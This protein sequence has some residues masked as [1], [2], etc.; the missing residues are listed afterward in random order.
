MK[1]HERSPRRQTTAA[2]ENIRSEWSDE[3]AVT[4]LTLIYE[5]MRN[6]IIF[7]SYFLQYFHSYEV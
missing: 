4:F 7:T 2:D 1:H 5:T 3:E 6:A